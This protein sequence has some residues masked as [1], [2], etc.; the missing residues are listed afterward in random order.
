MDI[1]VNL[2]FT[3]SPRIQLKFVNTLGSLLSCKLQ[4]KLKIGISGPDAGAILVMIYLSSSIQNLFN[5]ILLSSG[6]ELTLQNQDHL[7]L[8]KSKS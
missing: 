1:D 4:Q 8:W 3:F 6:H 7:F 5:T 2:D